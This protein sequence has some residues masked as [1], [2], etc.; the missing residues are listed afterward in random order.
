ML[1]YTNLNGTNNT[2]LA[3]LLWL[4]QECPRFYVFE[5]TSFHL[6]FYGTAVFNVCGQ[7]PAIAFFQYRES[8]LQKIRYKS[9]IQE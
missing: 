5:I 6:S 4:S 7:V 3:K 2:L 9:Y 8:A 1:L